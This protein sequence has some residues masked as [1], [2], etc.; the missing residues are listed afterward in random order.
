[1][2]EDVGNMRHMQTR[3]RWVQDE[4]KSKRV[5]LLAVASSDNLADLG[6]KSLGKEKLTELGEAC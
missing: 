1:M 5:T 3:M 2:Q 6:P 4:V